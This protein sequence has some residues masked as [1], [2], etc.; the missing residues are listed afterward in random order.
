[1]LS[2]AEVFRWPNETENDFYFSLSTVI[3]P[4][5][6]LVTPHEHSMAIRTINTVTFIVIGFFPFC[7]VNALWAELPAFT[8]TLPEG[9]TIGSK[10]TLMYNLANIVP[11][12]TVAWKEFRRSQRVKRAA[13]AAAIAVEAPDSL[14]SQHSVSIN[15]DSIPLL[16]PDVPELSPRASSRG[17]AGLLMALDLLGIL[18]C[19]GLL[20]FWSRVSSDGAHSYSLYLLSFLSGIVGCLGCVSVYSFAGAFPDYCSSCL[21]TGMSLSGILSA[22]LAALQFSPVDGTALFSVS[23][24]FGLMLILLIASYLAIVV[25]VVLHKSYVD[26]SLLSPEDLQRARDETPL[27]LVDGGAVSADDSFCGLPV[28]QVVVAPVLHMLATSAMIY[29]VQPSLYPYM[30]TIFGAD[31][32]AHVQSLCHTTYMFVNFFGRLSTQAVPQH[33]GVMLRTSLLARVLLS[34][35]IWNLVSLAVFVLLVGDAFVLGAALP[36]EHL[37]LSFVGLLALLN[38]VCCV[39]V[40]FVFDSWLQAGD[41]VPVMYPSRVRAVRTRINSFVALANQAG[42][43]TGSLL[44]VAITKMIS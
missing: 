31:D 28:K 20:V 34:P 30:A 37:V 33:R 1:M 29:C 44:A 21:S 5:T 23:L 26:P 7:L 18:T 11:F 24:F 10:I 14:A 6:H 16:G 15:D 19:V 2:I 8:R 17:G 39:L 9:D 4:P 42:S 13:A 41:A 36:S 40:Y 32:R 25:A 22:G 12:G 38:G 35:A 3:L 43:L 27:L